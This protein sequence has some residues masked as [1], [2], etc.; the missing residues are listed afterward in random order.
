MSV[1]KTEPYAT[2]TI[3]LRVCVK[4]CLTMPFDWLEITSNWFYSKCQN[5]M[6]WQKKKRKRKKDFKVNQSKSFWYS[7][8]QIKYRKKTN[9]WDYPKFYVDI[10][11]IN[12]IFRNNS[13]F[14]QFWQRPIWYSLI[15]K[16]KVI[17]RKVAITE[18]FEIFQCLIWIKIYVIILQT[19]LRT[20]NCANLYRFAVI[21]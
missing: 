9:F 18:K 5:V 12:S 19:L 2:F 4:T 10:T 20:C 3:G 21:K 7:F 8:Q 6:F 11:L 17:K 15:L 14:L 1:D 13:I 16:L